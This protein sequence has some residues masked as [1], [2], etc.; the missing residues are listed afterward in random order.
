MQSHS[1][2]DG[3]AGACSCMDSRDARRFAIHIRFAEAKV[4]KND[5]RLDIQAGSPRRVSKGAAKWP[6]MKGVKQR[7]A[8]LDRSSR[9]AIA[10]SQG[11]ANLQSM[12]LSLQAKAWL[13]RMSV[14]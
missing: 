1:N 3:Q 5:Q 2:K 6:F 10:N 7:S 9:P 14:M 12:R 8:R 4:S 11:H 13:R